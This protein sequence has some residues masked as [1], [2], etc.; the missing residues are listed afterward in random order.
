[1]KDQEKIWDKEYSK[2]KNKWHKETTNLPKITPKSKVLELGVGNAK[3]LKAIL[4]QSPKE[5]TAIDFSHEAI[6]QSRDLFR[7]N[8]LK[9]IRADVRELPFKNNSFNLIFCYYLL[10][11]L[12][13]K[14]RKKAIKEMHRVL[15]QK[16]IIIFEDFAV[17]DFRQEE[18]TKKQIKKNTI[19]N[20]LGIICHFFTKSEIK[21]LFKDFSK[22]K[23]ELKETNPITHKS[24]LKR[25]I[26]SAT[27]TK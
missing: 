17:G 14:G 3:T 23:I 1:M 15:A 8:N 13:E 25:K 2:N 7:N 11:N 16:G 22:I 10:N 24:Q 4:K 27:I 19:Q 18:K 5:V 6:N 12:Q 26:I 21:R 9:L 20:K